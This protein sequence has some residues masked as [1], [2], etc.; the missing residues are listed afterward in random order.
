MWGVLCQRGSFTTAFRNILSWKTR[1]GKPLAPTTLFGMMTALLVAAGL[2]DVS[3]PPWEKR[4]A[5]RVIDKLLATH[6]RRQA[7]PFT[8]KLVRR[9][10]RNTT[11]DMDVR[12]AVVFA[13]LL[14]LRAGTV[15][16]IRVQDVQPAG[17]KHLRIRLVAFKG[18][19]L[20]TGN[21]VTFV[22]NEGLMTRLWTPVSRS[23]R[24]NDPESPLFNVSPGKIVAALKKEMPTATGH[25]LR[26]GAAMTLAR[27]GVSLLKI[28]RFLNHKSVETTKIYIDPF[29]KQREVRA[30]LSLRRKLATL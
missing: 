4:R 22:K 18:S 25:S 19:D 27:C 3:P 13:W 7:P 26:R 28:S 23:L 15:R 21:V 1:F 8:P 5:K 12:R 6:V 14:G 11:V 10:F 16:M 29:P 2:A 20:G 17:K 24:E 9:V 30:I